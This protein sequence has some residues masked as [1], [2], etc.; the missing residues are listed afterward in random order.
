MHQKKE[1]VLQSG[2]VFPIN[3]K[4]K[5]PTGVRQKYVNKLFEQYYRIHRGNHAKAKEETLVFPL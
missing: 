5:V 3:L 4:G 2:I 1:N